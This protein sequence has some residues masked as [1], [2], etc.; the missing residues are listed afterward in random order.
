MAALKFQ[1]GSFVFYRVQSSCQPMT[2]LEIEALAAAHGISR[3]IVPAYSGDRNQ[4]TRA[5]S[6]TSA[7]LSKQGW[8][9]RPITQTKTCVQYGVVREVKGQK[10][11]YAHTYTLEWSNEGG[12]GH[13]ITS[14]G[15]VPCD[16]ITR[17]DEAYQA[18]RGKIVGG[19]WTE[20]L[21]AYLVGHCCAQAMREDGRVY[22]VPAGH[23]D[24]LTP[25]TAF[26][27]AVGISLVLAEIEAEAVPVVQQAA[28]EGLAEQLD[29]LQAQVAQFDGKQKP[30][31]YR[32]RIAEIVALKAKANAYKAAL[33]IG[34]EQAQ[35]ILDA[36]ETQVR[37]MLEIRQSTVVHRSGQ[38]TTAVQYSTETANIRA[39]DARAALQTIPTLQ[40]SVVTSW[41]QGGFSW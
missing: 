8:L 39:E 31:N 16:I 4:V 9:L 7:H 29:A 12:N 6:Q 37:G 23:M 21:T 24:S 25:L 26:L 30:S 1:R 5:I 35:A 38:K 32:E 34:V 10:L 14:K 13:A 36:L 41:A 40:P 28:S 11:D 18:I 15:N 27:A 20:S 22:F 3:A 17:V 19:D 33:G 2:P